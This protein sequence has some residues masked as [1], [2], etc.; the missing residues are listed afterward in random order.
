MKTFGSN[1]NIL[2]SVLF[3]MG[4]KEYMR[5][6]MNKRKIA[7]VILFIFTLFVSGIIIDFLNN[8]PSGMYARWLQIEDPVV[9]RIVKNESNWILRVKANITYY[10]N[11]KINGKDKLPTRITFYVYSK[12]DNYS[13]VKIKKAI[14]I[15]VEYHGKR[16]IVEDFY[17]SKGCY[18]IIMKV[19]ALKKGRWWGSQWVPC[20]SCRPQP[21]GVITEGIS[22]ENIKV[23][24]IPNDGWWILD[25]T[26]NITYTKKID[27][28]EE[29][30]I[31]ISMTIERLMDNI[32]I[33]DGRTKKEIEILLGENYPIRDIFDI[34]PEV[35][36]GAYNI[37]IE[38]K[39]YREGWWGSQWITVSKKEVGPISIG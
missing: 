24:P 2:K 5:E 30:K 4:Y 38:A 22:I 18:R 21:Y 16:E 7:G 27:E 35:R 13:K 25:I 33:K 15:D 19:D 36:A 8:P 29:E 26:G 9:I 3:S 17:V 14:Y 37:I 11:E 10:W 6:I 39:I 23:T 31:L 28:D 20:E 32:W 1:V 34:L 12:E